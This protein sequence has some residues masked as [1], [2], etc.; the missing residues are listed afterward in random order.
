M[1]A[2]IGANRQDALHIGERFVL[3]LFGLGFG[4]PL[5]VGLALCD[6]VVGGDLRVRYVRSSSLV[7]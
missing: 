3:F 4:A 7:A 2:F 6:V 1:A 5:G